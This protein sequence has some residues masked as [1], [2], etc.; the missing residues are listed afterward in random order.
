MKNKDFVAVCVNETYGMIPCEEV[1]KKEVCDIGQYVLCKGE[2]YDLYEADYYEAIAS[3]YADLIKKY[4]KKSVYDDLVTILNIR[5]V[6]EIKRS[7]F[8]PQKNT[9][10]IVNVYFNVKGKI[11]PVHFQNIK[12]LY[13][14]NDDMITVNF[15]SGKDGRIWL[16]DYWDGYYQKLNINKSEVT[17]YHLSQ[18]AD[19]RF[20][21]VICDHDSVLK[22]NLANGNLVFKELQLLDD[23][24]YH[25]IKDDVIEKINKYIF[26]STKD[27]QCR[28][29]KNDSILTLKEKRCLSGVVTPFIDDVKGIVKEYDDD[30]EWI[31]ICFE[32]NKD[33][34]L[35]YFSMGTMFKNMTVHKVYS[36]AELG[37]DEVNIDENESKQLHERQ[38]Y[39]YLKKAMPYVNPSEENVEK[40][41]EIYETLLSFKSNNEEL[42]KEAYGMYM[43]KD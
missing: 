22:S 10:E 42:L 37:L 2:L 6:L 28:I 17:A 32:R 1:N 4:G 36:I 26:Q 38:V 8:D 34:E 41:T 29:E 18:A 20:D 43:K 35:P 24:C 15:E 19:V 31:V 12:Y 11:I 40:M 33:V 14:E 25:D 13:S 5:G 16:D 9:L 7:I 27:K 3:K 23:G 39:K 21:F 30:S